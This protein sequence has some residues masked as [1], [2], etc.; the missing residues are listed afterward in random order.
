MY[1]KKSVYISIKVSKYISKLL[2]QKIVSEKFQ[3]GKQQKTGSPH[4]DFL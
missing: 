2:Y 3:T 1:Q 4:L